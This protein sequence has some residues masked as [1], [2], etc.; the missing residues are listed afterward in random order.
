MSMLR[1]FPRALRRPCAPARSGGGT[2]LA[3]EKLILD[4][5]YEHESAQPDRIYLTQPIGN[6]QVIDYTW[7][8][9]LEQSRRMATGLQSRGL[10]HGD[11]IA[12]LSK[13]C[14]HFFMAELAIWMAGYTTVAL[15]PTETAETVRFVLEHSESSL[16]FVGKLDEWPRQAAAVPAG[17]PCIA[18]PL[19]PATRFAGWDSI[20]AATDPLEDAAP[21]AAA[22]IAMILYTSGSTGQPKG[23]MQNF[24]CISAATATIVACLSAQLG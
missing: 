12:I 2:P 18:M 22:D 15:Y 8:Q 20:A 21:R 24:A 14:A 5:V 19:A 9:V 11:K 23:V 1:Q 10:G 13:N 4:Y 17:L 6:G 3:N 7:A 16:L